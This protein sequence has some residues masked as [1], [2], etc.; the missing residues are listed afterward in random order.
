MY[1][2]HTNAMNKEFLKMQKLAG[3][4]TESQVEEIIGD[5]DDTPS[6]DGKFNP[7]DYADD[8]GYSSDKVAFLANA[9]QHVWGMGKGNN[10]IDFEDMAKSTIEDLETRF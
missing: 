5:I 2:K 3:L 10:K 8:P 6:P 1:D 7:M 4:I 9:F